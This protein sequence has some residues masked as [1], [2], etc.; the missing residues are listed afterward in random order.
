MRSAERVQSQRTSEAES[1]GGFRGARH[2]MSAAASR[3]GTSERWR[4]C[5]ALDGEPY[6]HEGG[7]NVMDC[8]LP[9]CGP[10]RAVLGQRG[11][12]RLPV[13]PVCCARPDGRL[14]S[15]SSTVSPRALMSSGPG[16][17]GPALDLSRRVRRPGSARARRFRRFGA[18]AT[19]DH[20][21]HHQRDLT[22]RPRIMRPLFIQPERR[23]ADRATRSK[24]HPLGPPTSIRAGMRSQSDWWKEPE[25]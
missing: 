25:N 2:G 15:R 14:V 5:R 16:P 10:G 12:A 21:L 20:E 22:Q 4:E 18:R 11:Y 13:H 9:V 1:V 17:G 8:G 19:D 24:T 6:Q 7:E 23:E 3:I